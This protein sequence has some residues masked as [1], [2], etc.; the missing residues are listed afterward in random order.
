M[1]AGSTAALNLSSQQP[2]GKPLS[3]PLHCQGLHPALPLPLPGVWKGLSISDPH[4]CPLSP[5]GP[6]LGSKADFML[7]PVCHNSTPSPSPAP[8]DWGRSSCLNQGMNSLRGK[9]KG[10]TLEHLPCLCGSLKPQSQSA[11]EMAEESGRW[12]Q[13]CPRYL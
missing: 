5:P 3:E 12:P 2:W 7:H 1:S 6:T 9:P 11:K 4:P 8:L 13:L 10:T